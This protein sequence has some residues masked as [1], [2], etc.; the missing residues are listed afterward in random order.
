MCSLSLH[1]V[2][3]SLQQAKYHI[4]FLEL[5]CYWWCVC[6][7]H[8]KVFS[9]SVALPSFENCSYCRNKIAWSS[10]KL[11]KLMNN[12]FFRCPWTYVRVWLSDPSGQI[13]GVHLCCGASFDMA[14]LFSWNQP[15]G[16]RCALLR[17]HVPENYS[18]NRK[19]ISAVLANQ[20]VVIEEHG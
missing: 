8:M 12:S 11:K 6:A 5:V 19:P 14:V 7:V 17:I 3:L 16:R 9:S 13:W 2:F 1:K 10:C 18:D 20:R 4:F 15:S